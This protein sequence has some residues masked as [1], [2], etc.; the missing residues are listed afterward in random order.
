[1]EK[2]QPTL[3][4]T[5][6][7]DAE[8]S[9]VVA[10]VGGTHY[11]DVSGTCPHCGGEIQHWDLYARQP[12][13]ESQVARYTLRWRAKEGMKDLLKALSFLQKLIAWAERREAK[14]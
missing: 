8:T 1:M 2:N 12:Y 14:K 13:L 4:S 3:R 6:P 7:L 11:S 5:K 9:A 10:Q